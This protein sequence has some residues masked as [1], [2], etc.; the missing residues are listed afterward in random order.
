MT[1]GMSLATLK[2]QQDIQVEFFPASE[3]LSPIA[4]V[5]NPVT[6]DL[7]QFYL[8]QGKWIKN[9]NISSPV[10]NIRGGNYRMQY[11]VGNENIAPGLFVY[12]KKS[13]EFE[14][15][16]FDD[17]NQWTSNPYLP[18]GKAEH[19]NNCSMTFVQAEANK[20]AYIVSASEDGKEILILE[21]KDN[22]WVANDFFPKQLPKMK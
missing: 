17:K 6:G 4:N 14:F 21:V 11:Q 20:T 22:E 3:T 10:L 18:K 19:K 8:S 13:S 1:Y 2:S 12:S 9:S 5:A 15:F 16:Y 7:T